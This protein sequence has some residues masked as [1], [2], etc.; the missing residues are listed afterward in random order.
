MHKPV[1][2]FFVSLLFFGQTALAQDFDDEDPFGEP[3][4]VEP[5]TTDTAATTADAPASSTGAGGGWDSG[6]MG[7]SFGVPSGGGGTFGMAYFLDPNAAL[8]FD[9]G[10]VLSS[11]DDGMDRNTDFGISADVNY[12]M[13]RQLVDKVYMFL[14]FGGFVGI[15]ANDLDFAQRLSLAGTG[16]IGVE[17]L[18]TP[19]WTISG[20]T[21]GS[22][23][24]SNEFKNFNLS[25]GTSALFMNWYW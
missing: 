6:T 1:T 7:L 17:Y 20:T 13:Y 19:Q 23:T 12:R 3:E 5:E 16:G 21:G 2:A 24:I 22:L 4:T 8:R 11:V 18:F 9:V 15:A 25:T 14:Q 10:L